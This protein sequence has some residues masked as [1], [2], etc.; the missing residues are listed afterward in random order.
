MQ[1]AG[2][3]NGRD[4]AISVVSGC[5]ELRWFFIRYVRASRYQTKQPFITARRTAVVAPTAGQQ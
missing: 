5:A 4:C 2:T 3:Q 1:S